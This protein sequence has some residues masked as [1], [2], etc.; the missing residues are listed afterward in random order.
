MRKSI[1][2]FSC[3]SKMKSSTEAHRYGRGL[4]VVLMSVEVRRCPSCGEEEI[5]I[6]RIGQLHKVIAMAF[7]R[8]PG[9][10]QPAEI[11]FLRT[12]LGHSSSDFAELLG[13]DPATVSRWENTRKPQ[14]MGR[15]YETLLRALA[16][17]VEP[18]K[19]YGLRSLLLAST[20]DTV[21]SGPIRFFSVK[22]RWQ[23]AEAS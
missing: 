18:I 12:Y 7:A 9:R 11:R 2:C 14:T 15:P 21:V 10:L 5:V 19:E 6:P 4:D 23:L 13:V 1:K 17:N 16:E 20:S 3:G 22:D 8:K